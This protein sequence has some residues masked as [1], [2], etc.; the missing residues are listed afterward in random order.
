MKE[1]VYKSVMFVYSGKKTRNINK[2]RRI[3]KEIRLQYGQIYFEEPRVRAV[4]SSSPFPATTADLLGKSAQQMMKLTLV[5]FNLIGFLL[6]FGWRFTEGT[7]ELIK[8]YFLLPSFAFLITR[9]TVGRN[10]KRMFIAELK[11]NILI[12]VR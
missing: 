12:Y 1:I 3:M 10:R 4:S 6:L 9:E 2:S 7:V 8:K 11:Y 5:S